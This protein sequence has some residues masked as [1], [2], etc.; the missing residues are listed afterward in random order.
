MR[1]VFRDG[2]L[3]L[4]GALGWEVL[5]RRVRPRPRY[6]PQE[7]PPY[8]EFPHRV[9][10][11][12]GGFAG[13]SAAMELCR[14]TRGRD[15]VGVM[16]LSRENYFTFWPMLPGVISNDVD[17]RNLAQ[18]LRRALIRAGASFRRA[19]LEGVDPERGVVR[20]DGVEIP[21]DH[22]V[23]ALGGEPAYFGIPGVEEHCISLR[24]IADAEKIRNRVIERYEE[25][26]LARGEVPDSRL[27]FVVIGGGATGVETVAALHELVHGALAEDYPNLHP[28]RVRLTL[29][30]RNPEILK[31]LDPALRRVARRRLE[32]LNI[33]ILNGATARE[34]LKDRV[35]LEDGREI[36]SENVIWTAGARASRKL[37]ELPFPHHDRRGLEVD[38]GMRVRGFAN[39]W[40]V[41][42]CAANV[43][44]EGNPVPPNAQAAVQEGRA[45]ARN[46]LAAIDGGRPEPFRY[47]PLGQ[48][49]ELGSRFAVNEV[50]GV[51]FSGLLASLFWR[52]TYLYKLESPQNRA[53]VA[54]D[55]L[56]DLF[57]EPAVTEIRR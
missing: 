19:Q 5:R 12:G 7:R 21:Y 16:V 25:A 55:W 3:A 48:L 39:V 20:A 36:P 6:R 46:V 54:A 57:T 40:G 49:V 56:L 53:R 17:A 9:L 23:L 18:P 32:R 11:A 38:A 4:G 42:D 8:R 47:R 34:V 44:A 51:R 45:V 1:R 13:Y 10:V 27:S 52:L 28:R 35:V 37:E 33:R 15:D 2:A 29:V 50:L 30:D 22:L 26:T 24:G 41:G 43:D 14:L 31:E